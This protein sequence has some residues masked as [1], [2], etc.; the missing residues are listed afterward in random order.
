MSTLLYPPQ[1]LFSVWPIRSIPVLYQHS[2][3]STYSFFGKWRPKTH[4][5]PS[6]DTESSELLIAGRRYMQ[7]TITSENG[8]ETCCKEIWSFTSRKTAET[9]TVW[10]EKGLP[11]TEEK[12]WNRWRRNQ[13]SEGKIWDGKLKRIGTSWKVNTCCCCVC[14][15]TFRSL[16]TS[17]LTVHL[18]DRS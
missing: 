3:A 2:T 13:F 15:L 6:G 11:K 8:W 7:W 16:L 1:F 5:A 18:R 12:G 14:L 4:L 17:T 10:Q 9:R